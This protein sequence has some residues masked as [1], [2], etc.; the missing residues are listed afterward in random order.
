MNT[1]APARVQSD[2]ILAEV[3]QRLRAHYGSRLKRT[4]LFGSRARGDHRTDSDYDVAAFVERYGGTQDEP[5]DIDSWLYDLL[6]DRDVDVSI[7][8]FSPSDW[9]VDTHFMRHLHR[10]AIDL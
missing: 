4:V 7:K 2:P 1:A 5:K 10:D 8:Y 3:K 9:D 6:I